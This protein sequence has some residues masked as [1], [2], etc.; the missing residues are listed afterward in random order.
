MKIKS[1]MTDAPQYNSLVSVYRKHIFDV[2]YFIIINEKCFIYLHIYSQF[3]SKRFKYAQSK[4]QPFSIN[5]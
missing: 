4:V 3:P 2:I 5:V 1:T